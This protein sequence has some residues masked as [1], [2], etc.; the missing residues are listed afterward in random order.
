MNTAQPAI[1]FFTDNHGHNVA[2]GVHG[3]EPGSAPWLVCP[4]WWVSHLELDWQSEAFQAFFNALGQHFTV[5]R[6]DRPGTGLS[7]RQRQQFDLRSEADTLASLIEHLEIDRCTLL[8]NSCAGPP[9]I[10][11]SA[12]NPERVSK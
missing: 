12:E 7:D 11:Y 8:A 5:V 3:R 1:H 9:A 10:V 6:F 2:Y 4:A